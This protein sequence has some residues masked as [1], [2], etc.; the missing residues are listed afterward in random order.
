M[1]GLQRNPMSSTFTSS[2]LNKQP[3]KVT[4]AAEEDS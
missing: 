4:A 3:S 1:M 2:F